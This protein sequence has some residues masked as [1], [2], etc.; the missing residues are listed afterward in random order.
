MSNETIAIVGG[1]GALGFGLALRWA[2]AGHRVIIGS[3]NPDSAEVAANEISG[4]LNNKSSVVGMGN[5]R[6]AAA[7]D[8]VVIAVPY[9]QQ[10]AALDVIAPAVKGKIVID[11]TVPLMPPKVGTVQLPA[12]GSS[13]LGVQARLGND[14]RVVSAFQNVSAKKLREMKPLECEILVAS[15]DAEARAACSRLGR[16]HRSKGPSR[17]TFGE[18]SCCGGVDLG[19]DYDQPETQAGVRYSHCW[20][21]DLSSCTRW[22]PSNRFVWPSSDWHRCWIW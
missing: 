12:E 22:F 16:N 11:T 13:G 8:L 19:I 9:A 6:A 10:A 7:A 21:G 4:L 20:P 15:D 18:L 14:V 17:R 3:R 5:E 1:T 2:N